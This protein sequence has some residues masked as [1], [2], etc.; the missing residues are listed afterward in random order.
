MV[1]VVVLVGRR[2]L[3]RNWRGI[4]GVVE[5][6]AIAATLITESLVSSSRMDESR[7]PPKARVGQAA[8]YDFPQC[9]QLFKFLEFSR[10]L[11]F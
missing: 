4:T 10:N 2:R 6:V 11:D 1:M 5:G 3:S 9:L 7:R 8:H